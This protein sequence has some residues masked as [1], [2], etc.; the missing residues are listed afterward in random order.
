MLIARCEAGGRRF[1]AEVRDGLLYEIEGDV[2]GSFAATG[3]AVPLESARVLAP[4]DP[5]KVIGIGLNYLD[6]AR[7]FKLDVPD[8]P[9]VFFKAPS[10]IIA[11]DEPIVLTSDRRTDYE[12]E[13]AIIIKSAARNVPVEE[14]GRYILGY[15]CL[16]DV[17]D[18]IL[19][20]KDGQWC[21]AK[22]FD[23]FCPLGPYIATGIDASDLAITTTVNG[24]VRQSSRTSQMVFGPAHLVS[25]CSGF[26]TLMPGDVIA[27][28]TT[29]GIGRLS[30]GDV[31]EVTVE[32]IGTLRNP[33]V[34]V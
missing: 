18:R 10:S 32:R 9:I 17:S 21:R 31:V 14:A 26:M 34:R 33:V 20:K 1:Y 24:E 27:T 15:S 16:N 25:F 8:E 29:S 13:L 12:G 11:H 6:H 28:G 5:G 2:F 3:R 19:Q 30:H 7:E 23:T 4:V 22:S